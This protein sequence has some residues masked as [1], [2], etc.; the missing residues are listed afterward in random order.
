M[1]IAQFSVVPLGTADTSLSAY[2]AEIH[3][4]L[5]QSPLQCQLTPM[6][7]ILEG[8]LPDILAAIAQAHEAPFARGARRV[9]TTISIDDR[10][11]KPSTAQG[12]VESVLAKL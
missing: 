3:N 10:R 9:M 1:A 11:D 8:P 6:G 7:T 12:K 4:I 5:A 2:I